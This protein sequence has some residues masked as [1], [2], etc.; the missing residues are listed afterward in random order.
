[1][2]KK[3]IIYLDVAKIITAILVVFAHLYSSDNEIRWY[4]YAFH[5]PLFFFVSGIFHKNSL[6]FVE[7]LKKYSRT[8]L[9]PIG[10]FI[11]LGFVY[12]C[13]AHDP[14]KLLQGTADAFLYSGGFLVNPTVWFLLALFWVNIIMSL[15]DNLSRKYLIL[16]VLI[17]G[18]YLCMKHNAFYIGNAILVFPFF[19]IGNVFNDFF[20]HLGE[21]KYFKYLFPLFFA[22]SFF[23]TAV[24]GRVSC[25]IF[26][27]GE[28]PIPLNVVVFYLNAFCGIFGVLSLSSWIDKSNIVLEKTSNALLSIL[29]F[30][31][32]FIR[33]VNHYLGM[34]NS[35]AFS[36]VI[37]VVI[38]FACVIS[39]IIVMKMIMSQKVCP[40][41]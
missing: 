16:I 34:D 30:Q 11:V 40:D 41:R 10:F 9:T 8:I 26:K 32:F 12:S 28:L 6:S 29:G 36:F 4:I 2:E 13:F 17:G 27:F 1:M 7:S 39:D 38:V 15:Y 5:M 31:F 25:Q 21:K 35:I 24:N 20:K 3:R 37:S 22:L 14:V 18:G 33:P 23:M 19:F